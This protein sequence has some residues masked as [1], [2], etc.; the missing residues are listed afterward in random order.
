MMKR[1]LILLTILT[2]FGLTSCHPNFEKLFNENNEQFEINRP[3]L[4]DIIIDIERTSLKNWDRQKDLIIQ[5]DSLNDDTKKTLTALGI[6]S[7]ELAKNPNSNCDKDYWISLNV[8]YDWNI[9]KLRVV[10]LVYAPCDRNA[11]KNYH[12][13]DGYHRDFWGQGGDWFIYSDGD[14]I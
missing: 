5:V 8:V 6:G 4:N 11:E 2:V 14:F 1:K 3:V 7:I 10:Q 9:K 12:Y 13:F